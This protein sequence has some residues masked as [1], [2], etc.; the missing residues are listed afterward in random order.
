M[1]AVVIILLGDLLPCPLEKAAA[2]RDAV[3][4]LPPAEVTL[5]PADLF[6]S[7]DGFGDTDVL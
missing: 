1:A 5:E 3:V 2:K 7:T 4:A 6:E